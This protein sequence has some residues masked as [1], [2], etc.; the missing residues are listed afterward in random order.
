MSY[1]SC[2]LQLKLK[3]EGNK[4]TTKDRLFEIAGKEAL[5][6]YFNKLAQLYSPHVAVEHALSTFDA[7]WISNIKYINEEVSLSNY[8]GRLLLERIN[9]FYTPSKDEV[10]AVK[11]PIQLSVSSKLIV[12]DVL[13]LL[14]INKQDTK[15]TYRGIT[16]EGLSKNSNDRYLQMRSTLFKNAMQNYLGPST[17]RNYLYEIRSFSNDKLIE[18]KAGEKPALTRLCLNVYKGIKNNIWTAT[19]S[20]ETCRECPV[21]KTCSL[22]LL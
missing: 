9:S 3:L 13:D 14:L 8:N 16:F 4:Q 15:I 6:V 1:C 7:T 12:T 22:S 10:V 19:T 17:K 21:N 20:K 11:F 18:P 5:H 2:S